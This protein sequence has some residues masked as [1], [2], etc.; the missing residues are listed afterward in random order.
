MDLG[1][2]GRVAVITGGSSGIGLAIAK[3]LAAEGVDLVLAARRSSR[4]GAFWRMPPLRRAQ[5]MQLGFAHSALEPNQEPIVEE[6][7]MILR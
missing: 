4:R 2:K 6:G 7:G 1:L 3:A 5:D